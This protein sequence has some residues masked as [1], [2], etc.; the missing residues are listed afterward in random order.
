M[1]PLGVPVV[2]PPP[3]GAEPATLPRF[4]ARHTMTPA[5]TTRF[6][7]EAVIEEPEGLDEE[8]RSWGDYSM[9]EMDVRSD[10]RPLHEV[11]RHIA[12]K[13]CVLDPDFEHDLLWDE[14]KQSKL[15]ESVM[16]RIPLPA[17][18]AAE[19]DQGRKVVVDGL[20]RLATL[21]RFVQD[22]LELRLKN[23]PELDGLSYSALPPIFRRRIDLC[24]LIFYV[25]QYGTPER[26]RLHL[27]ER[28]NGEVRLTRQ[29]MRNGL[30]MGPA[31]Q[32]LKEEAQTAVF[33][34]ATGGSLNAATMRD[35]EFVNRFCA[36]RVLTPARYVRDDMDQFLA[37]ALRRM[38]DKS[39]DLS[40]LSGAFR[41][42]LQ[43]S[44][45]AFGRHAFR[46]HEPSQPRRGV[47]NAP[48][49]DV[50][51]TG[52]ARYGED[53]VQR[54]FQAVREG[55]HALLQ[56]DDFDTAITHGPNEPEKVR[57]RFGAAERML[58]EALG[59]PTD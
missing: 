14:D 53:R 27:F 42:G 21:H 56:N 57:C 36:F 23:R 3:P 44:L 46:K 51:A 26:A 41:R 48:L 59:A 30:F 54:N 45:A 6:L 24:T 9:D 32:F 11:M 52:L 17:F 22:R 40:A 50:M 33:E 10:P 5:Q 12:E 31:T 43:N 38:N 13:Y 35:R 15:I 8:D 28:V 18:Y 55:F 49:W 34:Q 25:I 29:Q 2:Q 1:R 37:D 39:F 16:M 58:E 20:N 4:P 47:L 19:D 7:D